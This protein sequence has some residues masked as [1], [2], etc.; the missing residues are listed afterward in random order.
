MGSYTSIPDLKLL[1]NVLLDIRSDGGDP[2]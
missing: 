1:E 2:E